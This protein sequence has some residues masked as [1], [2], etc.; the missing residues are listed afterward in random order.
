MV[1]V[2]TTHLSQESPVHFKMSLMSQA[3]LFQVLA[4]KYLH[5]RLLTKHRILDQHLYR[6]E[7]NRSMKGEENAEMFGFTPCSCTHLLFSETEFN[8]SGYKPLSLFA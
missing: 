8:W 3:I 7:R 2:L 6:V 1:P 4:S 5:I